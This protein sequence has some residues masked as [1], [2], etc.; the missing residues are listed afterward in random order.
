MGDND[1][2]AWAYTYIWLVATLPDCG[3]AATRAL[4][5]T[6]YVCTTVNAQLIKSWR[7]ADDRLTPRDSWRAAQSCGRCEYAVHQIIRSYTRMRTPPPRA[8]SGA[9]RP[10]RARRAPMPVRMPALDAGSPALHVPLPP[11]VTPLP[12]ST[13]HRQARFAAGSSHSPARPGAGAQR[14]VVPSAGPDVANGCARAPRRSVSLRS[15]LHTRRAISP[16]ICLMTRRSPRRVLPRLVV[17]PVGRL[18]G[19]ERLVNPADVGDVD[20]GF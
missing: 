9:H 4:H 6:L 1:S 11:R 13:P 5:S 18:P 8:R 3:L 19:R 10:C 16:L 2:A 17:L 14:E 15:P 12:W 7:L 20:L